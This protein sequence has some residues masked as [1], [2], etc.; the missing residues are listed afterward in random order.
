VR[1]SA[2]GLSDLLMGLAG[3]SAGA[4]S[5]FVMQLAGYPVLTL[6]AAVAVAPL[7]ALALR[8][9]PVGAPGEED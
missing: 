4:L 2:Q 7:L 6:L 5:G 3:A 9:V 8:P 1:P